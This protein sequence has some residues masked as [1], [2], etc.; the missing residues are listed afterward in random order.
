MFGQD[1]TNP[2]TEQ[3]LD[4]ENETP[5]KSTPVRKSRGGGLL[6]SAGVMLVLGG[7][8]LASMPKL[9]PQYGWI[10]GSAAKY[11]MSVGTIALGGIVLWGLGL[12][13]RQVAKANETDAQDSDEML[14]L[15]QL[16]LDFTKLRDGVQDLRVELGQ[17]KETSASIL[18]TS[19]RL[20][21]VQA[22]QGHQDAIFRLAAS[23]DQVG[24]RIEHRLG[25]QNTTL[26]DTLGELNTA[27]LAT[28]TL[29][30]E[31][32]AGASHTESSSKPDLQ[33]Q[34]RLDGRK[35]SHSVERGTNPPDNELD[36]WV[37]LDVDE[38]RRLGLLDT[39]DDYGQAHGNK[40]SPSV[41]RP[42]ALENSA[43]MPNAKRD[44]PGPL[45]QSTRAPSGGAALLG[46]DVGDGVRSIPVQNGETPMGEKLDQLK[47]LLSDA[48]VRKALEIMQIDG[49]SA[50]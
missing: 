11:G 49:R 23:L 12:V 4:V 2:E 28:H 13:V 16:V 19:A 20:S 38:P 10:V 5:R 14:I 17:V 22:T 45:P 48:R 50:S 25:T 37:E 9:A 6:I 42:R 39:L 33:I 40:T 3:A 29:V 35:R 47:T 21:E 18:D 36:V 44:Q 32:A 1:K 31:W 15:E 34:P 43:A 26:Q 46:R 7:I 30:S 41:E 24:A 8:A 27:I